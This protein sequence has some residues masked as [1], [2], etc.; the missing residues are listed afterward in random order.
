MNKQAE[1][2]ADELPSRGV[3]RPRAKAG[4][5][6]KPAV[7]AKSKSAAR[8]I[9]E[10]LA[11]AQRIAKLGSWEWNVETGATRWSDQLFEIV[12]VPR[13]TAPSYDGYIERVHPEDRARVVEELRVGKVDQPVLESEH[14]LLLPDGTVKMVHVRA[15]WTRDKNGAP[16]QLAGTTHDITERWQSEEALRISEE[17]F[18]SLV[19]VTAAI[20]WWTDAAG[21]A[22]EATP[23]WTEF[24]GMSAE[25]MLVRNGWFA[26][27]HPDDRAQA[28]EVWQRAA[29]RGTDYYNEYRLRRHDGAWRNMIV[30]GAPVAN[31]DGTVREWIGTCV[32]VTDFRKADDAARFRGRLLDATGESIIAT[33]PAGSILYINRFAAA[34][35]GWEVEEALGAN[36]MDVTVPTTSREQAE[37]IMELLRRGETWTGE[38]MAHRRDGTLFPIRA[39]NTPLRDE[40]GKLVAIIGVARDV[41]ERHA[42]EQALRQSEERYRAAFDQAAVGVAQIAFDGTFQRVNPRLCDLFGYRAEELLRLKFTDVTHRGDLARSVEL[43][44]EI[45]EQQRSFFAV[46]KRY[47]RKDGRVIWASSTVSLMRDREGNPQSL[48]AIVEDISAQK[49]AELALQLREIE[50]R[51]LTARLNAAREDEARRIAREL[52]DELGQALTAI[53][54]ETAD[55]QRRLAEGDGSTGVEIQRHLA[56]VRTLV[57]QAIGTTR[58]VCT[59]LRPALLDQ[60]GFVPALEWQAHDFEARSGIFCSLEL[61]DP[62]PDIGGELATALFRIFQEVLTNVARH[63]DATEVTV[64]LTTSTTEIRLTMQDNGRGMTEAETA[65][66]SGLGLIGIRERTLGVGGTVSFEGKKGSGT[67]V[68]I[69]V[70]LAAGNAE[71]N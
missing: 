22:T 18:R 56:S 24:T 9:A 1:I 11:T 12:G 66:P 53:T 7:R 39:S 13:N 57:D 58:R 8:E 3:T 47:L 17:R 4:K 20:S 44:G 55:A 50:L 67:R 38:F 15:V 23:S 19:T 27:V 54:L 37:E 6:R 28:V 34:Q 26:A 51:A 31:A 46:A 61:P 14:R 41:T 42:S 2:I 32:D 71:T 60:V 30:R 45:L 33:D 36:I 52:H 49:Q 16:L 64:E 62:A 48:I 21:Q 25:E 5:P 65:R 63:S 69:V 35:F 29:A 40:A 68:S 10:S 59:E 43:V 70:P